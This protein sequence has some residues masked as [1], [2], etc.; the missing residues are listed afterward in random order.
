[1]KWTQW[2]KIFFFI[3]PIIFFLTAFMLPS[4]RI[5]ATE[6]S[7]Y[8]FTWLDPDKEVYVLQ[9]RIYRKDHGFFVHLGGGLT[10]SGAFVKSYNFQARGSFF[11]H[12]DWG[13]Q[14]L[15]SK[16]QGKENLAAQSVRQNDV[17]GSDNI[18]GSIP[19]RRI[20]NNYLAGMIV[21]S[22]FYSKINTFNQIIYLDWM[23]SGGVTNI[24]ETNNRN[25]L[26]QNAPISVQESH[27]GLI[28]ETSM[29]IFISKH[30]NAR[31]DFTGIHY[32]AIKAIVSENDVGKS[33]YNNNDL[34][35]SIGYRF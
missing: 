27:S 35:L 22:P 23:L 29:L 1:M 6:E 17:Y 4:I 32:K 34:T 2:N 10:T 11:L 18:T 25:E 7:V 5:Q 3:F 19:F 12:E 24:N 8:D 21:W 30:W 14:I 26:L 28:W 33:W 13:I 15:Y 16:N 9:N 20:I 31:I